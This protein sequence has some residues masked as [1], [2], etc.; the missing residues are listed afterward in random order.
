MDGL[1][2]LATA[3]EAEG[4]RQQIRDR[5]RRLIDD[6]MRDPSRA[7]EYAATAQRL[8]DGLRAEKETLR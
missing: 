3:I 7:Y 4:R 2:H 6:G 1:D 5:I 8:R